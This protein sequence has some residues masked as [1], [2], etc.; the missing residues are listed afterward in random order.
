MSSSIFKLCSCMEGRCE[1]IEMND[2]R[3]AERTDAPTMKGSMHDAPCTIRRIAEVWIQI[4]SHT[5]GNA[6]RK[7]YRID[8]PALMVIWSI[9]YIH[10][11]DRTAQHPPHSS[12]FTT[13]YP[14]LSPTLP[15]PSLIH[16]W[17]LGEWGR[18][19]P[20][21][22]QHSRMQQRKYA[23][24]RPNPLKTKNQKR[25]KKKKE[26]K[27]P[28]HGQFNVVFLSVRQCLTH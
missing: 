12:Q 8:A 5:E 2:D 6:I 28:H 3:T 1:S 10:A 25:K 21:Q 27:V 24:H 19:T 14:S 16:R 23:I 15:L 13:S 26:K 7:M 11:N 17:C 22:Q 9:R 20:D 4:L 18:G